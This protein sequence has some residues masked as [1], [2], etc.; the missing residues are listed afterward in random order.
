[1]Y[2]LPTPKGIDPVIFSFGCIDGEPGDTICIPVTVENFNDI[3]IVQFE[4]FWNSSVLDYIEISNPG[5]PSINVI[6]DFNLSG[7]NALKFIPLGFPI[8]GESLPDG[9]VLFEICFRIIGFPDSTSCVGISPYFDFEVADINGVIPADS[10]N[11]CM[12]VDNAVTLWLLFQ[13]VDRPLQ[14]ETVRLM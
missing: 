2:P 5:S 11:C 10:V 3:V 1:M 6:A 13:V 4:I 9:T 12:T 14:V 8:D 7:P